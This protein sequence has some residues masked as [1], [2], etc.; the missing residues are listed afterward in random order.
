MELVGARRDRRHSRRGRAGG[1]S[2]RRRTRIIVEGMKLDGTFAGLHKKW[3]GGLPAPDSAMNKV[4]VGYGPVGF[5]GY[6]VEPH[7]PQFQ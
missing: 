2:P 1:R 5:E 7:R 6:V 4:W 3:F